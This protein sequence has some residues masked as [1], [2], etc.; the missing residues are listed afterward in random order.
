MKRSMAIVLV[1]MF[2]P[3]VGLAADSRV[4]V[5]MSRD[6]AIS[7]IKMH[8]GN[9][10]TPGLAV[11]GPNGEHPLHG[12]YWSL[13]GYKAVVV[14]DGKEKVEALTYWTAKEFGTSKAHRSKTAKRITAFTIDPK[15]GRISVEA[16]AR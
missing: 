11:V 8:G 3:L 10:I 14:V 16:K 5:G 1:W 9:D 7:I 15:A 12:F 2:F 13:D 6:E 4:E